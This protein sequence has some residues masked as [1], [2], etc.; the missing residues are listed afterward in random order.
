MPEEY[1]LS[2]VQVDTLG[3]VTAGANEEEFFLFKANSDESGSDESLHQN[4]FQRLADGLTNLVRRSLDQELEKALQSLEPISQP[5]AEDNVMELG[6]VCPAVEEQVQ[7]EPEVE[8]TDVS[9]ESVSEAEDEVTAEKSAEQTPIKENDGDEEIEMSENV[10]AP[11]EDVEKVQL[12]AT[13]AEL[14]TRLEKA[15]QVA[16]QERELRER[17]EWLIKSEGYTLPIPAEE[18]ADYLYWLNKQDSGRAEWLQGLLKAVSAQ[19]QD[20]A[21]FT[22]SGT[23]R[24]PDLVDEVAKAMR[25]KDP[26]NALLN[27]S[28]QAAQKYLAE[29]HRELRE[30]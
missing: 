24:A 6:E 3:L 9:L 27:I 7:V 20:A 1:E 22:E 4:W 30:A 26:R 17:R 11:V 2:N 15:E 13:L 25:E 5:V 19:L 14:Q 16:A 12:E 23:S 21:L 8:K 28:P 29:R 10:S 18:L